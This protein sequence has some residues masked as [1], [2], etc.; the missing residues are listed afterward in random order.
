MV[1]VCAASVADWCEALV[2]PSLALR[3]KKHDGLMRTGDKK[4]HA[5]PT[6]TTQPGSYLLLSLLFFKPTC[7]SRC[8][9]Q[10]SA[11]LGS[12]HGVSERG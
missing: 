4:L 8:R 6:M 11:V 3:Q 1:C 9:K 5:R 10:D 2:A 12:L 7:F